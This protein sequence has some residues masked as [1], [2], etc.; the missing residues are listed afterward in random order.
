LLLTTTS[1]AQRPVR[2]ATYNIRWLSDEDAQ[3]GNVHVYD[4]RT[5]GQ[6]LDRL[7]EVIRHL[8]ADIIGLQEIRDRDVL[9]L[10]FAGGDWTLVIDDDN[11]L[12]QDLALAVRRPFTVV[13]A[14][15]NRLNAGPDHFLFEGSAHDNAFPSNRDLLCVEVVLPDSAG[16]LHVMVHHAKSRYGGRSNTNAR[17]VAAARAMIQAFERD[18]DELNFVLLGDFNDNPD[19]ASL[20]ILE[21][22]NPNANPQMEDNLGTFLV[23]L[24]EPLCAAGHV[25]HGRTAN[26]IQNDHVNTIDSQSRQRN[27]DHR[28]DN[29]NTG[30]ILFDQILVPPQVYDHYALDSAAVFDRAVAAEGQNYH[31]ASDHLPVYADFVFP[32]DPNGPELNVRIV[33]LLPNPTTRDPGKEAVTLQN[34]GLSAV[35][36]QGWTLRDRANNTYAL[37]GT[38]PAHDRLRI[39]MQQ[40]T[41]PL[42][43]NGDTVELLDPNGACVHDVM[44]TKSQVVEGQDIEF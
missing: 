33:A 34:D 38:I 41:M 40:F 3:C 21:T 17:R 31:A 35:D 5:Q 2:I 4:V 37:S 6:R 30:D 16:S 18:F 14:T 29:T 32:T 24:T 44:Y 1:F 15:G 19:D 20:N 7:R 22:G 23:N 13:G 43:N 26:D 28:N 8:D 12:C 9:Q 42:N 10:V 36:L 11:R 39:V 25:S 27:Y